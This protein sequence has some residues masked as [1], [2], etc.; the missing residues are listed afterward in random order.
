MNQNEN[1]IALSGLWSAAVVCDMGHDN[2][3]VERMKME[4]TNLAGFLQKRELEGGPKLKYYFN[5]NSRF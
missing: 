4:L 1:F 2:L 5:D 3:Q